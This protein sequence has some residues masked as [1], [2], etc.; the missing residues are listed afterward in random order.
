MRRMCLC[1]AYCDNL[2]YLHLHLCTQ[3]INIGFSTVFN[4]LTLFLV[5]KCVLK[6]FIALRSEQLCY[7]LHHTWILGIG[8]PARLIIWAGPGCGSRHAS[9][10]QKRRNCYTEQRHKC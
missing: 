5:K 6:V 2:A 8:A 4:V 7:N 9:V 1:I 10:C 3:C